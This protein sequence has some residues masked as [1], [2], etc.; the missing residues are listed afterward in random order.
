MAKE[1]TRAVIPIWEKAAL[2]ADETAAYMNVNAELV[3][4]LAHAAKHGMNDFP[5]FWVGTSIKVARLP[6][7]SWL[8]D[9]AAAQKDLKRAAA[10]VEHAKQVDMTR[11][12]GRPR[13]KIFEGRYELN[14]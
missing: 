8:A 1:A 13:K 7:L 12:R 9:A 14:A 11:K 10:M 5:A 3:R 2:T 4:A 6:L